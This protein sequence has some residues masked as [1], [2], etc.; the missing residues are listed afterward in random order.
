MDFLRLENTNY[1]RNWTLNIRGKLFTINRPI[2]MGI[3]NCTPDSFYVDSRM[4]DFST[5]K[6]QI[7]KHIKDGATW[8]DLG[9]YSTRPGAKHIDATIEISRLEEAVNY[10]LTQYPN[11]LISVDTFQEKVARKVLE[12]GV[13][14]INDISGG[15]LQPKILNHVADYHVP[16]IQM[17]MRGTPATMQNKTSY[18]NV[19]K[20]VIFE[21]GEQIKIAR[22]HGIHDI[23]IDPGFGFAKTV[24]QNFE[25]LSKLELFKLLEAPIL[26]GISRKSFIYKTLETTPEE[27]LNGTSVLHSFALQKGANF[28]RCHDV[29]EACETI[30]LWE[31]LNGKS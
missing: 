9:A 10:C 22:K 31:K 12:M 16:Y 24:E 2:V 14:A 21:L 11:A 1:S 4:N 17:H 20:D 7:D 30:T 5:Q 19:V 29:K 25:L 3:V 18:S 13:H 8:L 23:I 15:T 6:E 26:V 28:L 27:A